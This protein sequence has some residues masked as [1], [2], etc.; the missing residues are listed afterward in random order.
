MILGF[1][2]WMVVVGVVLVVGILVLIAG[3]GNRI[4]R[5]LEGGREQSRKQL[6]EMFIFL[7]TESI[8]SLQFYGAG[9]A[10][11]LAGGV[12]WTILGAN[13]AILVAIVAAGIGFFA[14]QIYVFWISRKRKKEFSAQL[15]DALTLLAN[16]LR[17]GL[18]LQ[19]SIEIIMDESPKPMSEE[20]SLVI[21]EHQLGTD[22]DQAL[23]KCA[24]R[25]GDQDMALASLAIQTTLKLGGNLSEV[26]DR[27]VDMIKE[28]KM[29]F[30]KADSL[31]S[32]GKMQAVVVGLMPYFFLYIV[33]QVNPSLFLI[34]VEKPL[35]QVLLL[36]MALLDIIG[37]LWVRKICSIEF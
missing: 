36:I 16:S 17:S 2:A 35:G 7:P 31:T 33:N 28:R 37:Y 26:F 4:Q 23:V 3:G 25:T 27:M 15:V 6:E 8:I 11:L 30:E 12:F 29:I 19:Q 20:M 9:A 34:M 21:R 22:L 18:T 5:W 14:P 10:F 24:E 1:P 13:T 32:Q